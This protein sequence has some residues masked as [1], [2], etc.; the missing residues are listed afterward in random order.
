MLVTGW[1]D[2]VFSASDLTAYYDRLTT[3]TKA[4]GGDA[5]LRAC[6]W[7]RA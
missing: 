5:F 2:P 3:D 4:Q 7:C 6:S 1:S